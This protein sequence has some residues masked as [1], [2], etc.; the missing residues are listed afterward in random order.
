MQRFCDEVEDAELSNELLF[1]MRGSGPFQ[2]FKHAIHRHNI[3]DD[4]YR[5]RQAALERIAIDWLEANA[6][7]YEINGDRP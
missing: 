7:P 5:Y 4:W 6:I 3:A 1:Q 2:R